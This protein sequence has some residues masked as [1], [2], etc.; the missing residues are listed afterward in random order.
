[1]IISELIGILQA[2][3][4]DMECMIYFEDA[5]EFRP[6]EIKDQL[7]VDSYGNGEFNDRD[8]DLYVNSPPV[9]KGSWEDL[10]K[11]AYTEY[12]IQFRSR[13]SKTVL[14]FKPEGGQYL[15]A[16]PPPVHPEPPTT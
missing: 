16:P 8:V 14:L 12:L 13:P 5:M 4:Q 15:P 9:V 7:L 2:K 10:N 1:M 11:P 3:P 6:L